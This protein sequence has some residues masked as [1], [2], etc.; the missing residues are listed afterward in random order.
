VSDQTRAGDGDDLPMR[1]G[2]WRPERGPADAAPAPGTPPVPAPAASVWKLTQPADSRPPPDPEPEVEDEVED[3]GSERRDGPDVVEPDHAADPTV[4]VEPERPPVGEVEL[5][6]QPETGPT[7]ERQSVAES[8]RPADPTRLA[9]S[10]LPWGVPARA[11]FADGAELPPPVVLRPDRTRLRQ[12]FAVVGGVAAAV[13][14][15]LVL[16]RLLG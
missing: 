9:A 12:V 16:V 14:V 15:L 5:N 13:L 7:P 11:R 6:R 3:P 1:V 4:L 2:G 8:D 10:E